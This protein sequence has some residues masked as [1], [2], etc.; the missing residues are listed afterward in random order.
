VG[1]FNF[2]LVEFFEKTIDLESGREV[3]DEQVVWTEIFQ[4]FLIAGL[5]LYLIYLMF[6]ERPRQGELTTLEASP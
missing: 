4:P 6:P 5:V 1:T 3:F 2:D